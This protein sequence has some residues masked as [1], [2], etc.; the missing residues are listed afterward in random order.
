MISKFARAQKSWVA[1]LILTLTALSFMS[2]FGVTGY[3]SSAGSNRK[4]IKVD[5]FSVSQAEFSYELQ[6]EMNALKNMLGED[7]EITDE[8]RDSLIAAVA[9]KMVREQIL[10]RTAEKYNV[11]FR[12]EMI[13]Q[14][15]MREPAFL[16]QNGYFNKELFRRV[17]SENNMSES[18]YMQAVQ[19][20]LVFKLLAEFPVQGINVPE[21][22][23]ENEYKVDNKRR[24]FNYVQIK[25]EEMKIDRKITAEEIEQYYADFAP[26]F[27]APE[28][29]DLSVL[30]VS[31]E[32][33]AKNMEISAEDIKA[34][35]NEHLRDYETPEKRHTLQMMFETEDEALAAYHELQNGK[36]FY[37]VAEK[38]AGQ[39][40]EDTDLGLAAEDELVFEVAED[41]FALPKGGYIKPVQT[42]EMWQIMKVIDV[43]AP[44]KVNYN[45]ASAEIKQ[46]LISEGLYDSEY[47]LLGNL[48]DSL[49]AGESLEALAAKNGKSLLKVKGLSDDGKVKSVPAEIG[50]LLESEDFIDTAFSYA[51]GETSQTLETDDGVVIVRVD[52]VYEAHPKTLDEVSAEI[53]NMWEANEKSAIAQEVL[54]DVLH[55]LENG[56]SLSDVARR[57]GLSVYKSQPITRNE[58]FAGLSYKNVMDLFA[59]PLDT[60]HQTTL[61]ENTI[62]SVAV[63]DYKNTAPLTEDEKNLILLKMHQSLTRDLK[64][65]MLA[66]YAKDYKI[67]VKYKLMGIED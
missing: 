3:L 55:D 44:T 37:A 31:M 20:G 39:S 61:G 38:S 19:R 11:L 65:A 14:M 33:I 6:K 45:I 66:D 41:V 32:D 2:L 18:E 8:M 9:S 48:E 7:A 10:N 63:E 58:T 59:E 21:V 57:Y 52:D 62:I 35:Y 28:A 16:D 30:Y 24:R 22:L 67:R 25:P 49:A 46:E 12:P 13:Q 5:G 50:N 47:E 43:V 15:V 64:E 56:D 4:V 42:G 34:Y 26:N 54:N 36:D 29:R 17:L 60:P 27:V 23:L 53:K 40:K 1:K 51:L